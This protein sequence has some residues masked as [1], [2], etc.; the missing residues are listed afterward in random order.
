MYTKQLT[1]QYADLLIKLA[2]S[3]EIIAVLIGL[4]IS[5]V[6]GIS[7][8]DAFS[9]TQGSGFVAG[10][11]AILVTSLPFVLIA[12]VEICKIPLVFAFMAVKNYF[13]RGLFLIFVMFLCLITFETMF[14][15]F[16]RNFS[17][18]NRAIDERNNAIA[19][20]QAAKVLLE[21]RRAYI[22]KF[23]EEELTLELAL[24]R[25]EINTQFATD[26]QT[27]NRR[28][29]NQVNQISYAFEDELEA[30]IDQLMLTRDLYYTDWAAETQ[31]VEERFNV[32]LVG[33]ISGS[34]QERER[35]L[36][37]LNTLKLEFNNALAGAGFFTRGGIERKYRA[38]IA[39]KEK[40]LGSITSGYLGGDAITKQSTMQ[41]QLRQQIDFVN[42]KY[43]RR[44]DEI[45]ERIEDA[46]QEIIT[47]TQEN[48]TLL[49][50]IYSR[51]ARDKRAFINVREESLTQVQAYEDA[52]LIK[53][54]E[55]A[56][57]SFGIDEQIFELNNINRVKLSEINQ[58]INQNQVYRLA[59]YAYNVADGNAVTK[60]M[61]GTVAL[62]WFG[63]LSLIA[64][65]CGVM[66]A[67]AGFYLRRFD[68]SMNQ[69]LKSEMRT[70]AIDDAEHAAWL[71]QHQASLNKELTN[72]I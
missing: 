31:A 28:T 24:Q 51:D 61:L 4:T 53:L 72:E 66:L 34:S 44:V 9:Q 56:Q 18:L 27:I 43:Q 1:K 60:Q 58:L 70:D 2:W 14:N 38:L 36:A 65:V 3:V 37:E 11:S 23:T 29:S 10:V 17:N 48:E 59:M 67:L 7:A 30:K 13:W 55:M 71:S 49:N 68:G 41:D 25:D 62:L 15:G 40:Q 32:L 64:A 54:E 33:N 46:K 20:N 8:Y 45:N 42:S 52:Q 12:V 47:R 22:V 5:I 69:E 50:N 26:T 63:S 16:E 57:L 21:D 19:D 6:M 35:L 39:T